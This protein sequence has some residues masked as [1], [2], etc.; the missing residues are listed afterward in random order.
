MNYL[1]ALNCDENLLVK[2]APGGKK[3]S[4]RYTLSSQFAHDIKFPPAARFTNMV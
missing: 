3:E 2:L 4:C 1:S